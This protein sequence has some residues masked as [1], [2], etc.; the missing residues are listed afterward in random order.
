M[1]NRYCY[2]IWSF[3]HPEIQIMAFWSMT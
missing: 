1:E 3:I 2:K